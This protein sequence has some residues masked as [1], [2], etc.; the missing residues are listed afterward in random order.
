MPPRLSSRSLL[1][2]GVGLLVAALLVGV[3]TTLLVPALP[4]SPV[5]HVA[6][7]VTSWLQQVALLVGAALVAVAF[8]VRALSPA[9]DPRATGPAQPAGRDW[10]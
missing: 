7:S 10:N 5:G 2:A 8:A 6:F 9:D 1:L 4:G 3:L